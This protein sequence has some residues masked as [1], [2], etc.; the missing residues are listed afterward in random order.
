MKKKTL[1]LSGLLFIMIA[2]RV[3]S[4]GSDAR[5]GHRI[6]V[7][8]D[9]KHNDDSY[10]A[11]HLGN[12]QYLKDTT[13]VSGKGIGVFEGPDRLE[14]GLYIIVI[15]DENNFEV[16][17]DREQH[18]SVRVD[19]ANIIGSIHFEGSEEN[20]S[21]YDYIRFMADKNQLRQALEQELRDRETS[22][23]RQIDIQQLIQQMEQ[24]VADKQDAIIADDPDGML[25]LLLK[26]QRDPELPDPPRL[27][28]GQ[29]DTEVMYRIYVDNYFNN[30]DFNDERLLRTPV[31]HS[32]LRLLFNNVLIQHPDS[33]IREA[34]R[35]L[36]KAMANHEFF[37]YTIWFITNYA[38]TSQV[39]GMNK[40]FVH[41]VENY[42]LTDRV[43]WISDD[44]RERLR[45]RMEEIKPLLIGNVAPNI[46][47]QDPRKQPVVL[48]N[49]DAEY[50]VLYFWDSECSF[51]VQA[52]PKLEEAYN[53]L[54][55][56]GV[57]VFAVNTERDSTK[58]LEAIENYPGEWIHGH[59]I[60]NTSGFRDT[61]NIYAI[62]KIFILD[63]DKK[64]I[65]KDIGVEHV[66]QFIR[67]VIRSQ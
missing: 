24:E 30:I 58:W 14:S 56:Y 57:K 39:M 50:L 3:V 63:R 42:Y 53:N 54:V 1:Y 45:Q 44:R 21:F 25:A 41:M 15:D 36:E 8:F 51:C 55:D 59:D 10:L 26:S 62:P 37:R 65:A 11:F 38:E 16:I 29:Y 48:H 20:E 66:E 46:S 60:H 34:D 7:H 35:L 19:P 18:F 12:R 5:E 4:Y 67:E 6:K 17:I 2:F 28:G 64:I 52:T 31:Y 61:Y 33:I 32:R 13:S 43:D 27:P 23:Q 47:I 40:L 22:Q 49:I 9:G